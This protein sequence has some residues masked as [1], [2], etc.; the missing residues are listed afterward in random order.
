VQCTFP[1]ASGDVNAQR[2]RLIL[3]IRTGVEPNEQ[4]RGSCAI[5]LFEFYVINFDHELRERSGSDYVAAATIVS[6]LLLNFSINSMGFLPW[7][8]ESA[9]G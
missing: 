1:G 3:G 8:M 7:V 2:W 4:A 5:I 6:S 9:R